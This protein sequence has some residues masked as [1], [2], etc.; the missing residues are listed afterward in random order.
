MTL[1]AFGGYMPTPS[2]ALLRAQALELDEQ[3]RAELAHALIQSLDASADIDAE[4]AWADEITQRIAKVDSG[5]A[6][7][8]TREELL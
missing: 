6:T 2:L 7:L 1:L 4:S 8:L 3:E 5:Q